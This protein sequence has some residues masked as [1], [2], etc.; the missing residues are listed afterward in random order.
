[1]STTQ[2]CRTTAET[3]RT[4]LFVPGERAERFD[5]AAAA[6]ADVVVL[7]LED[8]VRPER[9]DAARADVAA[10]AARASVPWAVRVNAAGTEWHDADID[11]VRALGAALVMV[12]KA[13]DP[14]AV[15]HLVAQLPEGSAVIA[16]V[17]TAAGVLAAADVAGVPGVARL[18][19]GTYDLAA[20]L[21]VDP[22]STTALAPARGAL[23][24]AS[25]AAGLTGPIDGV[26]GEVANAA[27]LTA[28]VAAAVEVGFA[29]KLC[30]HPA[31]VAPA[32]SALAPSPTELAWAERVLEAAAHTGDGALLVDGRMVDPPVLARAHR[33]R[34]AASTA[35]ALR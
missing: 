6:G 1:M 35:G 22:D 14:D 28:D 23:V 8:A 19:L 32:A 29:G 16:L 31:Q 20:Q 17:E 25:A 4:W 9:K 13:E 15:A 2:T 12:P 30:V 26:T 27:V 7:D 34:A 3:A 10:W 5:K 18:A 24:L 21:G 33:A 11:A